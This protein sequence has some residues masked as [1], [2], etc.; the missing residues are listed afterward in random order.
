MF[1]KRCVLVTVFMEYVLTVDQT[2]GKKKLFQTK[3]IRVGALTD[4]GFGRFHKG[5]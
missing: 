5:S 1:L 4:R 2:G 3:T